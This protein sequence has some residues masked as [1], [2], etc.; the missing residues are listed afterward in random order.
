ML[1]SRKQ[2]GAP[3]R[4]TLFIALAILAAT[5]LSCVQEPESPDGEGR[6]DL[7]SMPVAFRKEGAHNV[8]LTPTANGEYD[9]ALSG[10]D[11]YLYTVPLTED[12]DP[13]LQVLEFEYALEA[14][15][16]VFQ[17]FYAIRGKV[18]E[19]SSRKYG[20][21]PA[22]AHFLTFRTDIGPLRDSGWGRAGDF[23]RFD[24]GQT[25]NGRMRVRNFVIREKTE[26]ERQEGVETPEER[27]KRQMSDRLDAYLSANYP[28]TVDWVSVSEDKVTVRGSCVGEGPFF[29][30]EITPWQDVTE[31]QVFPY[32][33]RLTG[34]MFSLTM[35]RTVPDREDIRD[36]RVFSKWAV[37][38]VSD[39]RQSICSHARY[40]DEVASKHT[41]S[42]QPLRHKK[43]LAAGYGTTYYEDLDSLD[44][45]SIT[46]NV[47]LTWAITQE[48][49]SDFHYGGISYGAGGYVW[50]LD[51]IT[52]QAANRDIVVSAIL[53]APSGSSY[54]DPENMGGYYSMPNLTTPRA[55]NQYAA[56]LEFLASRYSET[57]AT[58]GR[59]H[60]WI[61]HNEVDQGLTWTNMGSQPM[62][63]YLDRYL[64]SM[65]IC[66]NIVR[67]YDPESSV[68]ASFTHCWT[69]ESGEYAPK[70][71]LER[72]VDY[73]ATEGDFRWGVAYHPYP[74]NLLVPDFWV[75]DTEAPDAD[76][77]PFVTFRNPEVIDR[78]IRNPRQLY[79]GTT[80]RV[81][82]FS[83]NGTSSPTYKEADLMRQAAGACWI[84][85][86]VQ[87]LD[88]IDAI[89]W[90]SWMD[91]ETEGAQ[92]L[93][94]GLRALEGQ[95]FSLGQP[96]PVWRVWQAAGSPDEDAVF[97]P[98]LDIVGLS[99]WEELR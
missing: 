21:L 42:P 88:G 69:A 13:I 5:G 89:Q 67:Q 59:I 57:N 12:L 55:F 61:M 23:L 14:P 70:S 85:K 6:I 31:L 60:H 65:R 86:K 52:R 1:R 91:N 30:A 72:I 16:D 74:Q 58:H 87:Y 18:S 98:Y 9:L 36:D 35:D 29:L 84:W 78:W 33:T 41:P 79:R 38:K 24:P 63:R 19:T 22:S 71:M 32:V 4:Q 15:V 93:R 76:D 48:G 39:G 34:G 97:A 62:L 99:S 83:E 53:L 2:G 56:V 95:G 80:K 44:I 37:V 27:K 75:R 8:T 50:A 51:D 81:L 49:G 94:L 66:Y 96:K 47:D 82:F 77:A 7:V 64:K 54:R 68:L 40:A 43:G 10:E 28:C 20:P 90:H 26:E 45:A 11:P 25:G 73:S 3:F 46:M 92:G 17:L